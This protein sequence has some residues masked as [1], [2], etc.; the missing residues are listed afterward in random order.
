[1]RR[2]ALILFGLAAAVF[3]SQSAGGGIPDGSDC[4]EWDHVP[5]ESRD[6]DYQGSEWLDQPEWPAPSNY[7]LKEN[8][9]IYIAEFLLLRSPIEAADRERLSIQAVMRLPVLGPQL[10]WLAVEAGH[11]SVVAALLR[12]GASPVGINSHE[13]PSSGALL[14][15]SEQGDLE[16]VRMLVEAGVDPDLHIPLGRQDVDSDLWFKPK[17]IYKRRPRERENAEIHGD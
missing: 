11:T 4:C 5:P 13:T 17:P 6:Y 16:S 1:M 7:R 15:A 10:L 2:R 12:A 9:P 3:E 8:D 14:A